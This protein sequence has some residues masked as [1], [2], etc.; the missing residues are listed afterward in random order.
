MSRAKDSSLD[1]VFERADQALNTIDKSRVVMKL[2]AIRGYK[3]LKAKEIS[4]LFNANIRTI[5]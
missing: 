1:T 3:Y 5:F 4:Y 2:L